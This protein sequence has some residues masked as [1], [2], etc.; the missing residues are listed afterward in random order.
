MSA[1]S[2]AGLVRRRDPDRYL[3][4]RSASTSARRHLFALYAF[5]SEV[6]RAAWVT[7]EPMIAKV[8]LQFWRDAISAIYKGADIPSTK[9]RRN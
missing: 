9:S 1:Q 8:R 2:V 6:A 3:S 7:D 4:A 5:N